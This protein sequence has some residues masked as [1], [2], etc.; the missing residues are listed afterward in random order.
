MDSRNRLLGLAALAFGG[1]FA[2]DA[3]GRAF[4][5]ATILDGPHPG[6]TVIAESLAILQFLV[7]LLASFF[8]AQA[9][10]FPPQKGHKGL[11]DAALLAAAAYGF[12]LLS[13]VFTIQV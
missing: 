8:A 7:L 12:G 11:R 9:V 2:I 3:I 13:A 1:A 4:R 5:V 6:G 10:F